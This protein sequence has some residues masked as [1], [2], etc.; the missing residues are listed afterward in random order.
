MLILEYAIKTTKRRKRENQG[1]QLEN[2][3]EYERY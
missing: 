1:Q 3:N 2:S